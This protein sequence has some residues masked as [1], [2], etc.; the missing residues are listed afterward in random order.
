MFKTEDEGNVRDGNTIGD[1]T[2]SEL[3]EMAK[4][5]LDEKLEIVLIDLRQLHGILVH[6]LQISAKD[7]EAIIQGIAPSSVAVKDANSIILPGAEPKSIPHI[8]LKLSWK[9]GE[10]EFAKHLLE[11]N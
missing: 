9:K 2:E 6:C 4:L 7:D 5:Q 1:S 8:A 3:I 11:I 10:I